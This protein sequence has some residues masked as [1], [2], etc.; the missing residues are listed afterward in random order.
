MFA[1]VAELKAKLVKKV[2]LQAWP[3]QTRDGYSWL[4]NTK[5]Q[6]KLTD[7]ISSNIMHASFLSEKCKTKKITQQPQIYF[8]LSATIPRRRL[9]KI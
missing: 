3:W 6:S 2:T 8:F 9:P 4:E 5:K 7:I 1:H